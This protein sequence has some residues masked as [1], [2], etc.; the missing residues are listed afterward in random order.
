V[1]HLVAMGLVVLEGCGGATTA[2]P[3]TAPPGIQSLGI[4]SN[5]IPAEPVLLRVRPAVGARLRTQ[6][7]FEARGTLLEQQLRFELEM[8]EL[9]T[10]T[11][12]RPDGT[13]VFSSETQSGSSTMGM[14]DRPPRVERIPPS[15]HPRTTL[16]SE[17]GAEIEDGLFAAPEA[18]SERHD[19]FTSVFRDVLDA[20][21]YPLEALTPG[22]R[23][24][25]RGAIPGARIDPDAT[26]E[27]TYELTQELVRVEGSGA[28]ALALVAVRGQARGGG[29]SEG[30]AMSGT[31]RVEGA[32]TVALGDGLV[33][34]LEL[35]ADGAITLGAGIEIP[36]EATLRYRA[37]PAR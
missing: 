4:Q 29:S 33:R 18:S 35:R 21:A 26:G 3:P 14:G 23:W 25:A 37:E 2:A 5:E 6:T 30:E 7:R 16:M 8:V 12:R 31:I 24:T 32:Y 15:D 20:A 36:V 28:Q 9:R 11:D 13:T 22:Q 1:A 19:R 17:R 27:V 10:A 34:G